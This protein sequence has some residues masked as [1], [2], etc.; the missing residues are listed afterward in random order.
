MTINSKILSLSILLLSFAVLPAK[1]DDSCVARWNSSYIEDNVYLYTRY[2][3]LCDNNLKDGL[4]D[5]VSDNKYN[6]YT[7]ARTEMFSRLDNVDG[8]VCSVYS[9][10]C[11]ETVFIP[12]HTIMN[13]EHSWP[14]S[15]G[16]TGIAKSDLHHLFPVMMKMNSR[17]SNHPFCDVEQITYSGFGSYLGYSYW[18]TRCFEPPAKHKGDLAR[19]MF[20]FSVRYGHKIDREQEDFFRQWHEDDPVS[21]KE[22]ERN[23]NIYRFQNNRNP[24][25]DN[26]DFVNLIK[27]F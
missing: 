19:A 23:N 22:I 24:F 12:D 17:R 20:Y 14:Q 25:I 18:G 9:D 21:F 4:K 27:D 8:N 16:A 15:L 3:K 10:R 2:F 1:A 7:N 11:I 6:S 5:L 26:P 13:C